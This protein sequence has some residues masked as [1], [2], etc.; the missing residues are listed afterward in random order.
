MLGRYQNKRERKTTNETKEVKSTKTFEKFRCHAVKSSLPP[1]VFPKT[2]SSFSQN[3]GLWL[4]TSAPVI[5]RREEIGRQEAQGTHVLLQNPATLAKDALLQRRTAAKGLLD[6]QQ[7]GRSHSNPVWHIVSQGEETQIVGIATLG[8]QALLTMAFSGVHLAAG[9]ALVG[10]IDEEGFDQVID[11]SGDVAIFVEPL[12]DE[13]TGLSR[14]GVQ[15]LLEKW[16]RSI[17]SQYD[18]FTIESLQKALDVLSTALS[19]PRTEKAV[20]DLLIRFIDI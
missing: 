15:G 3:R 6:A 18:R 4:P 14:E 12:S 13:T 8:N 10:V 5:L 7:D 19:D 2:Q 11:W 9:A 16:D 1:L 20:K 17:S